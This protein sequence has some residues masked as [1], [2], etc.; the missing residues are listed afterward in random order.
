MVERRQSE[1]IIITLVQETRDE[2]GKI[3]AKLDKIAD[4]RRDEARETGK[5]EVRVSALESSKNRQWVVVSG[6]VV[7]LAVQWVLGVSRSMFGGK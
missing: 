4:E 7:A 1:A 6:V 5:I 2:L 3:N